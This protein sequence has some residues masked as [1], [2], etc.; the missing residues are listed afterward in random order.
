M[1]KYLMLKIKFV[2]ISLFS[3]THIMLFQTYEDINNIR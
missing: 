1:K 2:P 3:F